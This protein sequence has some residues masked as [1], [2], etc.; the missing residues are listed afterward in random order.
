MLRALTKGALHL[1]QVEARMKTQMK[2]M[3]VTVAA[4]S[5]ISCATYMGAMNG[6]M[7]DMGGRLD[8]KNALSVPICKVSVY[9]PEH[10]D[11]I[12]ENE[13]PSQ[14]LIAPGEAKS[15][16]YP[17]SKGKDGNAAPPKKLTLQVYGCNGQ[18]LGAQPAELIATIKDV[19]P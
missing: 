5:G 13:N 10:A 11:K 14:V 1:S 12:E 18:G 17:I 9:D 4:F 2:T 19:D 8:A 16:S 3:L 6:L 15:L 7:Q